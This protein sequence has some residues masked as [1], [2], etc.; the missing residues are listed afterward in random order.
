[1]AAANTTYLAGS[2]LEA[3]INEWNS[4]LG[5]NLLFQ[6]IRLMNPTYMNSISS[7]LRLLDIPVLLIW[8]E[9]DKITSPSLGERMKHEIPAARLEIVSG[10]GHLLLDEAAEATGT[11]IAAFAGTP[12]FQESASS[13]IT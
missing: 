8:G 1:M 4:A 10:A 13:A 6:H 12:K 3:Y 2:R 7:N 9:A 5:K 11:L